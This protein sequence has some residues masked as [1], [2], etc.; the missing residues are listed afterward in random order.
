MSH[1][2]QRPL[3]PVDC[4]GDAIDLFAA[5]SLAQCSDI[6]DLQAQ[7][8][9]LAAAEKFV[10][11]GVLVNANNV[12][13]PAT[14]VLTLNDGSTVSIDVSTL[15]DVMTAAQIAAA[16]QTLATG[17]NVALSAAASA[18]RFFGNDGQW[19]TL[20]VPTAHTMSSAVNTMT[21]VVNGVSVSA[22]IVNTVVVSQNAAGQLIVTVN[23][24]A[25][26][27]LSILTSAAPLAD[28]VGDTRAGAVGTA[29]L[30][31]RA[32]H[33]HPI[34]RIASVVPPGAIT[35]SGPAGV[36]VAAPSAAL[37][38][39]TEET[40]DFRLTATVNVPAGG[41]NTWLSLVVPALA[42]YTIE[43]VDWSARVTNGSAP[44]AYPSTPHGFGP[45]PVF[46]SAQNNGLVYINTTNPALTYNVV[47]Y[48]RY[49][50]N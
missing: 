32:D 47:A 8:D 16:L 22:P 29:T 10:Q 40:A 46:E 24:V 19:H 36:A 31:A 45:R 33:V 35:A 21:S 2:Y 14:L 3:N 25:S 26:A 28:G 20:T 44:Q 17:A 7:I 12:G 6:A 9:A 1:D 27:P 4:D 23:G 18:I 15:E 43:R 11:S 34:T 5:P 50:L 30:A 37:V 49:R 38:S 39:T 48:A 13:G 42:G 41:G